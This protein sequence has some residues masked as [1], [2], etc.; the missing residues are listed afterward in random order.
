MNILIMLTVSEVGRG[1]RSEGSDQNKI[2]YNL[3]KI[4]FRT[5]ST[6]EL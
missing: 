2:D 6:I 5:I 1:Q 3:L 4:Q